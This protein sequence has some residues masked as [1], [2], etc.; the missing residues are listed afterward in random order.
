MKKKRYILIFT[1]VYQSLGHHHFMGQLS[2]LKKGAA[3]NSDGFKNDLAF[4]K[5]GKTASLWLEPGQRSNITTGV[6]Q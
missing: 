4:H 3:S 5:N 1:N 6:S 2:L